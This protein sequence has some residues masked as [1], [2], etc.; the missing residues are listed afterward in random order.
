MVENL[1]IIPD[2]GKKLSLLLDMG[3]NEIHKATELSERTGIGAPEIS[4]YRR[5]GDNRISRFKFKALC[6]VYAE[7]V[8]EKLWFESIEVFTN[9]L[10]TNVVE[11]M[12]KEETVATS[13]EKLGKACFGGIDFES[14]ITNRKV[15]EKRFEIMK[16]YWE[17]IH[18]S[19]SITSKK[20]IVYN[21]L[22]I[23]KLNHDGY[24]ECCESG[25]MFDYRGYCFFV[26][27]STYIIMEEINLSNELIFFITNSP[28]RASAPILNGI[29]LALTGGS[30]ELVAIP[31]SVKVVLRH[32][33]SLDSVKKNIN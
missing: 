17:V 25:I 21:L 19:I 18:H 15:L 12:P 28:D 4:R 13:E 22:K 9:A 5:R 26:S 23:E 10:T 11:T 6:K 8:E 32:V 24:I 16:G 7:T 30:Y 31:T 1:L 14:R 27:G 29:C 3:L 33:G 2:L 20:Y